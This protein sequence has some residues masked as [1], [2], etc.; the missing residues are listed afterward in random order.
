MPTTHEPSFKAIPTTYKGIEFRS[1]LEASVAQFI[2]RAGWTWE[3]EPKSFLLPSGIHFMPDFRVQKSR[4]RSLWVESRGYESEKGI[5]QLNEFPLALSANGLKD[6]F[7]ILNV[8]PGGVCAIMESSTTS[9]AC[10]MLARCG[11]CHEYTAIGGGPC[12]RDC[13]CGGVATTMECIQTIDGV[14]NIG[15]F[16]ITQWRPR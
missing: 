16:P 10:P 13:D 3:Y 7:M 6:G 1:R 14:I 12:N 2:D 4:G 11:G 9:W 15:D 5:T 8:C